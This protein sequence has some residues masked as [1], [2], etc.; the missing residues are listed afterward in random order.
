MNYPKASINPLSCLFLVSY[1]GLTFVFSPGQS[2]QA[3][4]IPARWE[5]NAY[6]PPKGIGMPSGREPGGTR[7]TPLK[8]IALIPRNNFGVTAAEYPTF[9]VYVPSLPKKIKITMQNFS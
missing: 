9:F 1:L 3:Q 2:I 6:E 8:L 5:S 4:N 7:G